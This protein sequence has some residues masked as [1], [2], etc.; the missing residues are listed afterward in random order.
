MNGLLILLLFSNAAHAKPLPQEVTSIRNGAMEQMKSFNPAQT[1]SGFNPSPDIS[2]FSPQKLEVLPRS[3]KQTLNENAPEIMAGTELIERATHN[4]AESYQ[5]DY[6]S[7]EESDDLNEGIS[8]L[9][10]VA[11]S[12]EAVQSNLSSVFKG[13]KQECERF[14]W[15]TRDCCKDNG[16]LDGLV[17]CPAELQTLQRAKLENRAVY[18]GHYKNSPVA[19]TRYVYCVFP[20]KLAGII[21]NQG[22]FNQLH[23]PFGSA[24][25]PNCRG[26]TTDE[27]ARIDFRALDLRSLT[28]EFVS[29]KNFPQNET[30]ARTSQTQIEALYSRRDS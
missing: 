5:E 3:K 21:Q 23:I 14:I 28:D 19:A 2:T 11:G 13:D 26:I 27:L 12:A 1:I 18:I 4:T 29:K 9:G 16:F 30:T 6:T 22:R 20:T 15:G 10:A 24:K 7:V 25:K 17:N 8:R